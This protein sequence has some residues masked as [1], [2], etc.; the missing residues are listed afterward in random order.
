MGLDFPGNTPPVFPPSVCLPLSPQGHLDEDGHPWH[1]EPLLR[2][3]W[4]R[5][6][7]L[8]ILREE[9]TLEVLGRTDLGVKRDG[10]LLM[11]TDIEA[12]VERVAGVERAVAV[13]GSEGLRGRRL[14][15]FCVPREGEHLEPARIRTACLDLMPGYAIPDE[16]RLL[17]VLPLLPSGKVDRQALRTLAMTSPLRASA[18]TPPLSTHTARPP[19]EQSHPFLLS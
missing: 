13:L 8:C 2:D 7:E 17:R 12:T 5:T 10:R 3:G 9:E 6:R 16:I 4:Y 11:L 14:I 15:A 1:D 19:R 18:R